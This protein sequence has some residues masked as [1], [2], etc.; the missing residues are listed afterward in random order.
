M[1]GK[2]SRVH[3]GLDPKGANVPANVL[4]M[5]NWINLK[6]N[7]VPS[8]YK[9]FA[10]PIFLCFFSLSHSHLTMP[11]LHAQVG[12]RQLRETGCPLL[13]EDNGNAVTHSHYWKGFLLFLLNLFSRVFTKE[14]LT[15]PLQD[16]QP[17][18]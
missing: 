4:C 11:T 14:S 18:K 1:Y 3:Y 6:G 13:P 16:P 2:F 9:A 8:R 5:R 10:S 12:P 17:G 7:D 15:F